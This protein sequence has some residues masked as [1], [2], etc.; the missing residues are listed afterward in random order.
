MNIKEGISSII[1][2]YDGGGQL[3]E[4]VEEIIEF[5][6]S[7][8]VE[9]FDVWEDNDVFDSCGL[10]IFYICVVWIEQGELKTYGERLT[11]Y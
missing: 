10:D 6:Y 1:G 11:R 8:D 4:C 9:N 7:V 5:M 2:K 3:F